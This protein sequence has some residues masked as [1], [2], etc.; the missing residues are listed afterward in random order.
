MLDNNSLRSVAGGELGVIIVKAWDIS[1]SMNSS[2][3]TFQVYFPETAQKF[4]AA[5]MI[6]KDKHYADPISLQV[7]QVRLKLVITPV[8]TMR[9]DRGTTIRAKNLHRATVLTMN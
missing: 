3:L 8:V 6:S 9:D 4:S 2:N 5:T 1:V 7:K